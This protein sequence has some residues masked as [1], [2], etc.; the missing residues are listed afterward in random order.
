LAPAANIVVAE[1][2]TSDEGQIVGFVTV[3]PVT[4]YLDQIVVAPE[5]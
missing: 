2:S 3:D 5:R 1:T 4:L